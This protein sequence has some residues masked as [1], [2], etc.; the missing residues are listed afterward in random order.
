MNS[1]QMYFSKKSTPSKKRL[2]FKNPH[3]S[4]INP[5]GIGTLHLLPVAGFHWAF[6][7]TSLDKVITLIFNFSAHYRTS[8]KMCTRNIAHI[9]YYVNISAGHPEGSLSEPA[10]IH[11]LSCLPCPQFMIFSIN[12]SVVSLL[13]PDLILLITIFLEP[14]WL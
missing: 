2:I 7:S 6:P 5:A 13:S 10:I 1:S 11:L 8:S 12:F 9:Y 3:L 4:E 14:S